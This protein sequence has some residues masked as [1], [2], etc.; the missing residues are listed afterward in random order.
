TRVFEG[1]KGNDVAAYGRLGDHFRVKVIEAYP[2]EFAWF[3]VVCEELVNGSFNARCRHVSFKASALSA[4][5]VP[6][7]RIHGSM[8]D[9]AGDAVLTVEQHAVSDKARPQAGTERNDDEILHAFR[10]TI[11][12]F[13]HSRRV[14]VIRNDGGHIELLLQHVCEGYNPFPFQV[15]SPLDCSLVI[16]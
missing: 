14:G 8:S 2:A 4:I 15:G 5:A 11:N 10:G 6:P 9:L 16:I 12:H 7:G 3:Q 1:G 13:A